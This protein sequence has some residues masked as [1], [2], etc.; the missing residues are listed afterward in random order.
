[1]AGG[2]EL[3]CARAVAPPALCALRPAPG[4]SPSLPL[5]ASVLAGG[6]DAVLSRVVRFLEAKGLTVR[7][8]HEI[9]PELVAEAGA[10]G[11]AAASAGAPGGGPRAGAGRAPGR[12]SPARPSG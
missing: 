6:D 12:P 9:A 8:A 4:F 11:G 10:I 3:V 2:G 1:A 5:L 7:G